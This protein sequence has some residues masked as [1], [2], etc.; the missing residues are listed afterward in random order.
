MLPF[1]ALPSLWPSDIQTHQWTPL[2]SFACVLL[3]LVKALAYGSLLSWLPTC[4]AEPAPLALCASSSQCG[5][6]GLCS[7]S[8]SLGL[9]STMNFPLV[10]PLVATRDW[11]SHEKIQSY[12]SGSSQFI[13]I[14]TV[15]FFSIINDKHIKYLSFAKNSTRWR[16]SLSFRRLQS[17]RRLDTDIWK[18]SSNITALPAYNNCHVRARDSL[19]WRGQEVIPNRNGHIRLHSRT[20]WEP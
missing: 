15:P 3:T 14:W 6:F 18:Y 1:L 10:S 11:P 4:L 5:P 13:P 9:V 17:I 7:D 19:C 8:L 2:A 20:S 16:E 12:V